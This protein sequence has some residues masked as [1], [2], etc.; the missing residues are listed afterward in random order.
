MATLSARID[1]AKPCDRASEIRGGVTCT[2]DLS[3]KSLTAAIG[4]QTQ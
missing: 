2:I 4:S 1:G 3:V